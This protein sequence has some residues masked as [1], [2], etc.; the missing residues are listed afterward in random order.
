METDNLWIAEDFVEVQGDRRLGLG[1]NGD[2]YE[3][4][5]TS[6]G[7]AYRGCVRLYGRCIGKVY[8]DGPDGPPVHI[9]WIFVKRVPYE[10]E[11]RKT[12]LQEAW[13][14]LHDGPA[15]RS[16]KYDYHAL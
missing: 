12:Y 1:G 8:I 7:D 9:G 14:T 6:V 4:M 16:I 13:I 10:D 15:T 11:P 3:S 2:P 5:F